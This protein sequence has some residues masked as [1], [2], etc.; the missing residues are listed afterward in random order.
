MS[1]ALG[2]LSLGP[3]PDHSDV[4]V[5]C[6]VDRAVVSAMEEAMVGASID[7]LPIYVLHITSLN[8]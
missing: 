3:V 6:V 5:N 8:Q 1:D 4:L 7:R 2:G